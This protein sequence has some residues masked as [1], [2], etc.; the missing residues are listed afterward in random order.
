MEQNG[1][2]L[3]RPAFLEVFL[4]YGHTDAMLK[5][6]FFTSPTDGWAVGFP[7]NRTATILHWDGTA[8]AHVSLSPSLLGEI[9]PILSS[10]YMTSPD[11]GWIVGGSPDFACFHLVACTTSLPSRWDCGSSQY[12]GATGPQAGTRSLVDRTATRPR[13]PQC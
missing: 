5:S 11:N 6:V 1:S 7:G 9:P 2:P 3:L 8:W 12:F 13:S 10:V 4:L